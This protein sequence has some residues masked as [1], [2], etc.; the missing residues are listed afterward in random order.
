MAQHRPDSQASRRIRATVLLAGV[1]L[2]AAGC[3]SDQTATP[4]D[5]DG[6]TTTSEPVVATAPPVPA[7]ATDCGTLN[8]LA[9]WPTTTTTPPQGFACITD[10]VAAGTPAQMSVIAA[11]E[12]D[13][14]ETVQGGYELPTKQIVTWQVTG[15]DEV[16]ETIDQTEDGGA[17]VTR[18]CRGLTVAGPRPSG[19]DCE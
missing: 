12:G 4:A 8:E 3:G 19:T 1:L 14:G 17:S 15:A 11:G 13:S 10:A 18:T 5:T 16:H 6:P 9:G 7:A 2:L